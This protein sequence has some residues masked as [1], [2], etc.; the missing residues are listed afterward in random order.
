MKALDMDRQ[1]Y[2]DKFTQLIDQIPAFDHRLCE[3]VERVDARE[4]MSYQERLLLIQAM[5]AQTLL[6]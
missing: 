5:I 3:L 1:E 6:N 2:S 4:D